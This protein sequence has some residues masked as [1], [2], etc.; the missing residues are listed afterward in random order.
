MKNI[1]T[2]LLLLMTVSI[3]GQ[4]AK[5]AKAKPNVLIITAHPDDWEYS[6]GGTAFLMKDKY[7]IHVA[8]A[9]R[10]ERGLSKEPSLNT[11][12]IRVNEAE[13]S[14]KMVNATN[15][16]LDKI[17]GE[18]Y[19]DRDAVE[20]LVKLLQE[21]QPEIIFVHW[22]IDKPDHSAAANM[23]HIALSNTG[24]IYDHEIYFFDAGHVS[25]STQFTPQI[26]VNIT[27]V[28]EY[29]K[30]LIRCHKCQNTNDFL[31]KEAEKT[32]KMYGAVNRTGY[33]EGFIP[34]YPFTNGRWDTNK[35]VKCSL[36][37][38]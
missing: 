18:I 36:F 28:Y 37:D 2:V 22:P 30:Q 20:K 23:A 27:P 33:A 24:M 12:R 15:H 34:E 38:L 35:K 31:V 6:M 29:K 25:T 17:D 21:L 32:D 1:A 26:Y 19:A 5:K 7:K 8:I 4:T 3:Y 9:S 13:C 10:G 14:A 11:A 16:Y